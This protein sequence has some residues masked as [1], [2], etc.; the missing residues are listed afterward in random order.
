MIVLRILSILVVIIGVYAASAAAGIAWRGVERVA[1]IAEVPQKVLRDCIAPNCVDPKVSL[2]DTEK[3][4]KVESKDQ[5]MASFR[6]KS[7]VVVNTC[8]VFVDGVVISCRAHQ[9][10]SNEA[11]PMEEQKDL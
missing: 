3:D 5:T 6:L 11:R 7:G 4:Q 1:P 8:P 2:T 10:D 9:T